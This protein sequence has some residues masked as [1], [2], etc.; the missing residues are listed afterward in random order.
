MRDVR[1]MKHGMTFGLAVALLA[2]LDP[3]Q[4]VRA[5]EPAVQDGEPSAVR[6][7]EGGSDE[8]E[9]RKGE[10]DRTDRTGKTD[11]AKKAD[12]TANADETEKVDRASE[13]ESRFVDRDGDGIQDGQE[14]RF[15][16]RHRRRAAGADDRGRRRHRGRKSSGGP[17]RRR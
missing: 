2:L 12:K 16:G 14:H 15:R 6:Q 3:S 11:Q 7:R 1:H 17:G 9:D 10:A 4:S 8:R 13:A 5:E